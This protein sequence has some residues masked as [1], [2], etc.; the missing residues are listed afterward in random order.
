MKSAIL[1]LFALCFAAA[2]QAA[3]PA[4]P[5]AESCEQIRAE[6]RAHTGMPARPNTALLGKV[7]ANRQCRFTSAEAYRAAWGDKPL[8]KGEPRERRTKHREHDDD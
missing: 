3:A 7:G 2:A 8:P 4:A 1:P 6:I 5:Q